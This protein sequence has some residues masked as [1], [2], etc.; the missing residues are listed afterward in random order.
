MLAFEGVYFSLGVGGY[1]WSREETYL[2][3]CRQR[4]AFSGESLRRGM[5]NRRRKGRP[6]NAGTKSANVGYSARLL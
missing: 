2:L 6:H 4:L 1:A 3:E 5:L